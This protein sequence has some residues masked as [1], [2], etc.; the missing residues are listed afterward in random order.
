M[1][2]RR[3]LRKYNFSSLWATVGLMNCCPRR[4][5]EGEGSTGDAGPARGSRM[6]GLFRLRDTADAP[7]MQRRCTSRA[8]VVLREMT[9]AATCGPCGPRYSSSRVVRRRAPDKDRSEA[10][11]VADERVTFSRL[12]AMASNLRQ[13]FLRNRL[14]VTGKV[15]VFTPLPSMTP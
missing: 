11:K 7:M 6:G 10:S 15:S 2:R 9:K 13:N 5:G 1:P 12:L 4:R 3:R 8:C 14:G